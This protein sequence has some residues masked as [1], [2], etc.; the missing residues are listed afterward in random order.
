MGFGY[1]CKAKDPTSRLLVYFPK[2]EK[3]SLQQ[4]LGLGGR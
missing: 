3:L 4:A 2:I 1:G